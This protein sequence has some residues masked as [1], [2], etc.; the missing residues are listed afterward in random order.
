VHTVKLACSAETWGVD[1][2]E[3]ELYTRR[4]Q[5]RAPQ[6]MLPAHFT[7]PIQ[8]TTNLGIYAYDGDGDEV[9]VTAVSIPAN[10]GFNGRYLAVTTTVA[11]VGTTN[12]ASFTAN[13][14]RGAT[15]SSI[16]GSTKIVVPVDGDED[17]LSDVWEW[18]SFSSL[19]LD[20]TDD[21]DGDGAPN[22]HEA[23]AGTSPTSSVSVFELAPEPE[24]AGA[25]CDIE[26]STQPGRLYEIWVMDGPLGS[27]SGWR[28]FGSSSNGVGTWLETNTVPSHFTFRD[29]FT[30]ATGGA[31]DA[32]GGR[33]YRVKT[34]NP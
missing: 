5:N 34:M 14:G 24:P 33:L 16:P 22:L 27:G 2:D 32:S 25:S 26:V 31:L 29:Y 7:V 17:S 1:V 9:S 20:D 19:A 4:V 12:P 28:R 6:F 8:T 10:S 11:D 23:L 13:D 30:P 21:P 15:N 18:S 3:F